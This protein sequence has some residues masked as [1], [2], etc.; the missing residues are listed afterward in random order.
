MADGKPEGARLRTKDRPEVMAI[1]QQVAERVVALREDRGYSLRELS[2]RCD[3]SPRVIWRIEN[4]YSDVQLGTLI[5]VANQLGVPIA[6]LVD[7][8]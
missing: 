6:A 4:A 3:L 8:A 2:R 5:L 7:E 1:M